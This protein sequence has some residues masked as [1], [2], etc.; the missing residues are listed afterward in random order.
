MC[1][2]CTG[3]VSFMLVMHVER[4]PRVPPFRLVPL[5]AVENE[6][7]LGHGSR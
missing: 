7:G 2:S 4:Q 1:R 6:V 3:A 5:L